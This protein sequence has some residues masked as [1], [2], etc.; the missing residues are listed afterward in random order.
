[1]AIIDDFANIAAEIRRLRA[2]QVPADMTEDQPTE[3][4]RPGHRMRR[5]IAGELL[6]KRLVTR[7][8]L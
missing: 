4:D 1:M 6:Y 2:E 7:R 5:T 3:D 8:R